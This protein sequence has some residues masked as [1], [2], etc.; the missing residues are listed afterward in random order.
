V[1]SAELQEK[2]NAKAV[3]DAKKAEKEKTEETRQTAAIHDMT[4][5]FTSSI[6]IKNKANLQVILATLGLLDMGTN[7]ILKEQ[8]FEANPS[9]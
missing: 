7:M 3:K 5:T 8:H 6:A 4:I 9:N 1:R 2:Q